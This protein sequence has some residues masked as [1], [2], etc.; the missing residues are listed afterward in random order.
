MEEKIHGFEYFND[1]KFCTCSI[2][3]LFLKNPKY[4]HRK[5][6]NNDMFQKFHETLRLI[7]AVLITKMPRRKSQSLHDY[8]PSLKSSSVAI[9]GTKV[10]ASSYGSM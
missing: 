3:I 4:I 9:L 2:S 5:C 8:D 10:S 6:F 7:S 1:L